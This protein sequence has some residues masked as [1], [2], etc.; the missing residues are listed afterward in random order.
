VRHLFKRK[1]P[2]EQRDTHIAMASEYLHRA[3]R[4][5]RMA[6]HHAADMGD[7]DLATALW[8]IGELIPQV[9]REVDAYLY[10]WSAVIQP[11]RCEPQVAVRRLT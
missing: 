11:P 5:L 6:H 3:V 8:E 7:P 2:R 10:D 4:N 1:L 9:T